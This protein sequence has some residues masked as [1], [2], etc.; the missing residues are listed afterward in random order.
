MRI[1]SFQVK[2]IKGIRYTVFLMCSIVLVSAGF[3]SKNAGRT[4]VESI[5][6]ETDK[7]F[8]L[9]SPDSTNVRFSNLL[10]EINEINI[11]V[12]QYFY[13]GGGV[14]IGDINNDNLPDIYF[15][16]NLVPNALYLNKGDLQ[17]EDI[18]IRAGVGGR[19]GWTT[20]VTMADVNNDGFMDI[21]VCRSGKVSEQQRANELFI[22]NGDLS[23]TERAAEFGLADPGYSTQAAFL[24][25][26][27]DGDLDMYLLN[28]SIETYSN[29]DV[30]EMR[31]RR[32]P[33]AGDKLYR[34]DD[35]AFV[36][37]S[38]QAGIFGH[39]LGYGLG[40]SIADLNGDAWPDIYVGNDF[41]E[42][43][44]LY[45]NNG[46]GSFSE[47]LQKAIKHTSLYSMGT[48]I[49]DI[50]NDGWPDIVV[51]DMVA[52]DNFRQ[53]TNM[54]GM[55]RAKFYE[56]IKHG[57]HYQYMYNTLQLNNGDGNFSEIGH[58]AG[59]SN[60]D[61]S[62]APLI[63][64]FD[65]DGWKD[66][67]ITNGYRR[68]ATNNDFILS[69]KNR[70][71]QI[72][73]TIQSGSYY[74]LPP[75]E[76]TKAVDLV[77]QMPSQK[78][79]NYVYQNN[80]DLTFS[81]RTEQWGFDKPSFSNG[82]AFGDLDKDG[83][84]DLVI[85]NIDEPAFIYRNNSR[86]LTA[87][88]FLSVT[89]EGP[90]SNTAGIGAN[91]V[92]RADDLEQVQELFLTRGYQSSVEP[93]IHFG[94]G[95]SRVVQELTVT[96]PD[97]KSQKLQNIPVDRALTLR[98][99]DAQTTARIMQH[100]P[101]PLFVDFTKQAAV[102]YRHQ[103][104]DFDDFE[105]E[106]L[107][108]HKMSHLGPGIA[109]GDVNSDGLDD[110]YVGGAKGFSGTLFL[111]A[112]DMTF[113]PSE[114]Q[115]WAADKGSEDIAATFFDADGD[116]DLDLYVVSG[117]NEFEVDSPEL[118]DRMYVN[119]GT[120]RFEKSEDSLPLMLTSG[121]CVKPGD[122]DRDGDLDLFVGGRLI[123][124][125]YPLTPRSY[126]LQNENGKFRDVT[127]EIAPALA[128]AGLVTDGVWTDYN[129]DGKLD[130]IVVGEW[131]DVLAF[132]NTGGRFVKEPHAEGLEHSNGWWFSIAQADF[133]QDGD[134]DYVVGNLGLNYK[135]G[136]SR[137]QP[138]HVYC[139]DF[140]ENG[141]LDIVLGYYNAGE[142][143][144]LRGRQC[145]SDQMPFI[146]PKF[147][148]YRAFA[149]ATLVDVYGE[150]KL[151]TALHREAKTF[152]SAY[153]ENLG[154]GRFKLVPLPNR[155]QLSSINGILTEDFDADGKLDIVV[156]GNLYQSEPETPRNDASYGQ[157][158]KG[159]GGAPFQV[160]DPNRSGLHID[161]DVKGLATV[162]LGRRGEMAILIAKNDDYVQ[163][164][165]A[166]AFVGE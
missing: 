47:M 158:L 117:G 46:D 126:I 39:P 99:D 23:F 106:S 22:N 21:Y 54:S 119:D 146:Q 60:T 44:Y 128:E 5:A 45:I 18:T 84:L 98:Y 57:F 4:S 148:T 20:G 122:Y 127:Y 7:L 136:A 56:A 74:R 83:D 79:K 121:A 152:A 142:L 87:R 82:A 29:F 66:L 162:M 134:I 165:K 95:D 51:L 2:I 107:L 130:F 115:V 143:Y 13:N 120:G 6:I 19:L 11:L 103:E 40:V 58:L 124:G 81:K 17:F 72:E 77:K 25:Y 52:E 156:A 93:A 55:N 108:P 62:W 3:H 24:D 64:D 123:P 30:E 138:F 49:A 137:E 161:G 166:T 118:Q 53:K 147:P 36:D 15:T 141:T 37:V 41:L 69:L 149:S 35:G 65:N 48:D 9:L 14:A 104:N 68:D 160:V 33:Y 85:N 133:D 144:P 109:V 139:A 132:K 26:D 34:N 114:R 27:R 59:V 50:N 89:L 164:I 12:Y 67:F 131:M 101:P 150:K 96:W 97:G 76:R 110:F 91:I 90:P 42:R 73:S 31:A 154:D 155:V 70:F 88:H 102:H 1:E 75:A 94:F 116:S 112:A 145:S 157:F 32:D 153:I 140:D 38:T 159:N 92:V 86:E 151:G 113:H 16:G 125:K 163:I 135:Y 10:P 61:W 80:G 111:Q 100:Q 78:V 43:D 28:H 8:T 129:G 105:R 63:A 71:K